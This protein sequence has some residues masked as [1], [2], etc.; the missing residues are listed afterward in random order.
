MRADVSGF[1][2]WQQELTGYV[3]AK[4]LDFVV[5]LL[6]TDPGLAENKVDHLVQQG[7]GPCG[8][9]IP[10]VDHKERSD[11]IRDGEPSENLQLNG[12][13]MTAQVAFEQHDPAL[14]Q[15]WPA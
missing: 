12:S 1:V 6:P 7:E 2:D 15:L 10:I 5:R 14:S 13:V 9:I 4:S 8:P 11:I 3:I